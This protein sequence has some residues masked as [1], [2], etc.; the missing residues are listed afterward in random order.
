MKEN[1]E[2]GYVPVP[3]PTVITSRIVGEVEAR[4]LQRIKEG[5]GHIRDTIVEKIDGI[6][7][8]SDLRQRELDK[9]PGMIE[10]SVEHLRK[11]IGQRLDGNDTAIAAA[12]K[13]QQELFAERNRASDRAIEK[14]EG[15]TNKL[16][17]AINASNAQDRKSTDEKVADIKDRLTSIESRTT[18]ATVQRVENASANQAVWGYIF[19]AIGAIIGFSGLA[20]AMFKP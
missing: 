11:L 10:T 3:D 15:A 18:G 4:L 17:D 5:D 7:K 9:I 8:A 12:L 13:S 19:G 1:P 6:I 16:L 20:L 2:G 14:S